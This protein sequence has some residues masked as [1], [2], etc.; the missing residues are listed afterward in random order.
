MMPDRWG[1]GPR[2]GGRLVPRYLL[3]IAAAV[4]A[5]HRH[6]SIGDCT[7]RHDD[8]RRERERERPCHCQR[9]LAPNCQARQCDP[10]RRGRTAGHSVVSDPDGDYRKIGV[11]YKRLNMLCVVQETPTQSATR[12]PRPFG[13]LAS[14][15]SMG[16]SLP[17]RLPSPV[18]V[19]FFRRDPAREFPFVFGSVS[20]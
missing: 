8:P 15:S 14:L 9:R 4:T 12:P 5:L 7:R 13:S 3:S 19:A 20:C 18:Q 1:W 6:S 2:G 16:A 17:T 10:V 11:S